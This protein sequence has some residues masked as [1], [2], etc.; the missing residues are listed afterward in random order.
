MIEL[1]SHLVQIGV[2]LLCAYEVWRRIRK[3]ID[4]DARN[5]RDDEEDQE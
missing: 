5:S 2:G 1:I 4:R 3:D